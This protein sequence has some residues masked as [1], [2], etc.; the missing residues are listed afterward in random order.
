MFTPDRLYSTQSTPNPLG[1][2]L[3]KTALLGHG[4][5]MKI[6]HTEI[7]FVE[8]TDITDRESRVT[9]KNTPRNKIT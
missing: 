8:K 7:Q 6:Y 9:Q 4:H 5:G 1:S 2:E 3:V